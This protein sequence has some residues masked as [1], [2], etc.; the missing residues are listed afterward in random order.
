VGTVKWPRLERREREE[1]LD[2]IERLTEVPLTA[3]AVLLVPA[4]LVPAL[5][6]VDPA[7]DAALDSLTW[8]V[9][10]VFAADLVAKLV[11][12]PDRVGY[13]RRHW[14]DA[15]L[16]LLPMLRPLRSLHLLRLLW[17]G[18]AAARFLDGSR[19]L[20]RHHGLGFILFAAVVVTF[21]AAALALASEE[22]APGAS[23]RSFPDAL[24]WAVTTITTVGYG[25]TYPV[26]ETGRGVAVA[27]MLLGIALFGVVTANLSAFFVGAQDDDTERKLARIEERLARIESA[28]G[29][30]VDERQ[31][32]SRGERD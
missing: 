19:R 18:G 8:V 5:W 2:R 25:D 32:P 17:A 27:L 14:L 26:T 1:L 15:A 30:L 21:S 31:P 10:G 28:L 22:S 9:W 6:S 12:A 3:L 24:W 7:V 20:F 13:L 11:V 29:R 23:I 16:V 4:L